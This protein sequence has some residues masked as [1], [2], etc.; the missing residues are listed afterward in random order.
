MKKL[1]F[2]EQVGIVIP[3]SI[4]IFGLMF[5]VDGLM[6]FFAK[7]GINVGG[8]G[9]FLIVSYATGHLLAALGYFGATFYWKWRGG[10]PSNWIVGPTPRLLSAPQIARVQDL[11]TSRLSAKIRPLSEM[12]PEEWHPIFRQIYSDVEK[13]GRVARA[14]VFNGNYGLNRGLCA[15]TLVLSVAILILSPGQWF[16]SLGLI[17]ASVA[18]LSRTHTF[19]ANYAREIYDQF[20]LL[21]PEPGKPKKSKKASGD[22]AST[23]T[24][25]ST[26]E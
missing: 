22:A 1:S 11:V 23:S 3:G 15:A 9:V 10:I 21:P 4:L 24:D 8:L 19:G 26:K 5:Y 20:L 18:Y 25:K 14:D 6:S 13:N 16:V 7:D 17:A 2:Y 12:T